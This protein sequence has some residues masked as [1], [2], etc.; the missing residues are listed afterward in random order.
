M[1]H[2]EKKTQS[3]E[4]NLELTLILKLTDEHFKSYYKITLYVLKDKRKH[5]RYGKL[6]DMKTITWEIKSIMDGITSRL[7]TAEN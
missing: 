6:P 3:I 5:G 7:N 2:P 4:A 1:T